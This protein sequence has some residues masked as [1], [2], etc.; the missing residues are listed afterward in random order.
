MPNPKKLKIGDKVRFVSLPDEWQDT[1]FPVHKASIELMK[2]LISR[3][4][5]SRVYE[6]DDCGIPWIAVRI[7]TKGRVEHH[8]W[9]IN[10]R[11]GWR[12]VRKR[13]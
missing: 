10:E 1:K 8:H 2:V 11:T 3:S 5:P 13:V 9:G 4:W 7:R 6:I 12:L